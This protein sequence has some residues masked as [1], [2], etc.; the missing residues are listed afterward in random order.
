MS[1]SI[2]ES[3]INL[4]DSLE[5]LERKILRC[6]SEDEKIILQMINLVSDWDLEKI[7]K[8]NMAFREMSKKWIDFKKD[9]LEYFIGLKKAWER[10]ENKKYRFKIVSL[11]K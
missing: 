6:D 8:A 11:F 5:D 1:K 3:S 9:Y 7:N 2:P 10:T 4:D